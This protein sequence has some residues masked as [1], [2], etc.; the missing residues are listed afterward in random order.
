MWPSM[1]E[2]FG[3]VATRCFRS[4]FGH[5]QVVRL[6]GVC[7]AECRWRGAVFSWRVRRGGERA[8]RTQRYGTRE[9]V[10]EE[11]VGQQKISDSYRSGD[12]SY[13][14]NLKSGHRARG[15]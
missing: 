2:R 7:G 14:P 15:V 11:L 6:R 8:G 5:T 12:G 4:E 13:F 3:I 10:R 1:A 9:I